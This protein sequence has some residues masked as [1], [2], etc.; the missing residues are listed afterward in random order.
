MARIDGDT[1]ITTWWLTRTINNIA[2]K[3]KIKWEKKTL[4]Y[5]L[6]KLSSNNS[7]EDNEKPQEKVTKLREQITKL[8]AQ[9]QKIIAKENNRN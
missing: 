3:L 1:Q 8:N 5:E 4:E 7:T 6:N 9:L 2:A